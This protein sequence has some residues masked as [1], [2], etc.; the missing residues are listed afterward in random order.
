MIKKSV[1]VEGEKLYLG[2]SFDIDD[3]IGDAI[4]WLH[5]CNQSARELETKEGF[6]PY[7][8]EN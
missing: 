3:F 5:S 1:L 2:L 8:S 7:I 6:Y 4:F